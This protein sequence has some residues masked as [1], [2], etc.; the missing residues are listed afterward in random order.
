MQNWNFATY[1]P[2]PS[3]FFAQVA[4]GEPVDAAR[5]AMLATLYGVQASEPITAAELDRVRTKFLKD[6]DQTV[7]DPQ[8]FGVAALRVD[9]AR[10]LAVVLPAPRPLAQAHA[11]GRDA[12]RDRVAQAREPH[13]R[14]LRARR[15]AR[16]RARDGRAS[17]SARSSP[18]TRA[19]PRSPQ[20]E[21]FDPTPA[22]LEARTERV[23]LANGMTLA[24]LP[25][26]TRGEI[27]RFSLRHALRRRAVAQ[28]HARRPAR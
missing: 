11:G 1:D 27:V 4:V 15:E 21:A 19:T 6:F 16:S 28:G 25:K 14:H 5:D 7:N 23:K 22:N 24:M 9:R 20:G 8:A 26:K 3:I 12:R 13:A 17:T 2:G 18:T 10:R